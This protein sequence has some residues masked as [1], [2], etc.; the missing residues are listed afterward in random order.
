MLFERLQQNADR[1]ADRVAVADPSRRLTF[2]QL[3]AMSAGLGWQIAHLSPDPSKPVGIMLPNCAAFAISFFA[4]QS[5]GRVAMPINFLLAPREVDYVVRHSRA[6]VV[7]ATRHFQDVCEKL[8]V[9]KVYLEDIG[10]GLLAAMLA[11]PPPVAPPRRGD[12]TAVLL[13]TSG[14]TGLPKG[15][16]LRGDNLAANVDS[17]IQHLELD[18]DQN[19]LGVLPLFHSF[20]LMANLAVPVLLGANVFYLPRFNPRQTI[21]AIREKRISMMMAIA[22]M[23]GACLKC[24]E[25]GPADLATLRIAVSGGE[26]LPMAAA[27][28]FRQRFDTP[29]LQ[30]YGLTETS[31]VVSTNR[32][33][34]D[35]PGTVGRPLPGV[36][37]QILDEDDRPCPAG[38]NGEIVV[39]GHNVMRGYY[40]MDDATAEVFTPDGGLRTGDMGR[41]DADGYLIISG[42]KKEMIIVGGENVY[43]AE[44]EN[45][46]DAHPK[47][48]QSAVIGLPDGTRGEMV[49][50]FVTARDPAAPP[51]ETELRS[52]CRAHLAGYKIPRR[53]E[54][55]DALPTGPTG[56]VLRRALRE[57]EEQRSAE[58][59]GPIH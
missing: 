28:E 18:P 24:K 51:S 13:Y 21:D 55:V 50:A 35:R 49:A 7:L 12:E 39:H 9:K 8:E 32:P 38:I 25:G 58:P 6:E 57:Q 26:P 36:R 31:P 37:V 5:A 47:V 48:A 56:K 15:V 30:G 23:F 52:F 29:I 54:L 59:E 33:R 22:S 16:M 43:P 2:A 45:V 34:D 1:F 27:E 42:R 46:L 53:V 44:V 40:R 17:C 19:I 41:I 20:G 10:K 4:V 14:S 11:D 3:R